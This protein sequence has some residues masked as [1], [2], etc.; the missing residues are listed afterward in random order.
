MQNQPKLFKGAP[1]KKRETPLHSE[2]QEQT[3]FIDWCRYSARLQ[4]D[5]RLRDALNWI[6]SIPNGADVT[7]GHRA[8]LCREGLT[9][10][11]HDL[12]VD[13]VLRDSNGSINCPGLIIEM[14]LPGRDYTPE[15]KAYRDFMHAQGF[16]DVLCRN[17]IEAATSV[18]EYMKL[19]KHAPIYIGSQKN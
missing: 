9:A 8:R 5:P 11:V 13:Y 10:G 14:K 1:R 12:R 4:T 18:I 3:A 17:W 16:R 7:P 15:Q 6:H 2:S 19:E